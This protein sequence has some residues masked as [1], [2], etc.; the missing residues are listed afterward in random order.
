MLETSLKVSQ[1]S[2]A[3]F[4]DSKHHLSSTTT[5]YLQNDDS[6]RLSK[7]LSTKSSKYSRLSSTIFTTN[8]VKT[9]ISTNDITN[10]TISSRSTTTTS[11]SSS[12]TLPSISMNRFEKNDNNKDLQELRKCAMNDASIII[13]GKFFFCC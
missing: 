3:N 2:I 13:N 9:I 12:S 10:K 5:K 8:P 6:L 11:Q 4:S 7:I 1:P